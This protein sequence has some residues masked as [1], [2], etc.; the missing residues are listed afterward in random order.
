M[1]PAHLG[2]TWPS[3]A[4]AQGLVEHGMGGFDADQ[5]RRDLEVPPEYAVEAMAA[6]AKAAAVEALLIEDRG[7]D[8]YL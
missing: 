4:G 2:C 7:I 8:A 1:E 5:A 3:R 6:V